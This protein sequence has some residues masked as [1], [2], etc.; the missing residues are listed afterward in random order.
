[1]SLYRGYGKSYRD[2]LHICQMSY[3]A[4]GLPLTT[5]EVNLDS[6]ESVVRTP[7]LLVVGTNCSQAVVSHNVLGSS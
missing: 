1:M 5:F 2:S 3:L 6:R 4:H 7:S